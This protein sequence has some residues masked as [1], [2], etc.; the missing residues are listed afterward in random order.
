MALRHG[1]PLALAMFAVD[2]PPRS[3]NPA[4]APSASRS[5]ASSPARSPRS[6]A[7]TTSSPAS[8][9]RPSFIC[10]ATSTRCGPRAP[11]SGSA[12][13]RRAHVPH[14]R[15][16]A[17]N[18]RVPRRRR[19]RPP[20]RAHRPG[21]D[22]RPQNRRSWWRVG[23]GATMSRSTTPRTNRPAWFE[24]IWRRRAH[25]DPLP[26]RAEPRDRLSRRRD[27]AAVHRGERGADVADPPA[28]PPIPEPHRSLWFTDGL[29]R[30]AI[31]ARERQDFATAAALLDQLLASADLSPDDRAAAQWLRGLEDLRQQKFA[32]EPPAAS[33]RPAPRPCSPRSPTACACSR[34]RPGSTAASPARRSR[35]SATW[36]MGQT[37]A[38]V[39]AAIIVTADA[40]ARTD[41]KA[42]AGALYDRYLQRFAEGPRRH[43]VRAKWA[44]LLVEGDDPEQLQ[45]GPRAV[46]AARA[47]RAAQRLRRGG[48]ARIPALEQRLGVRKSLVEA[49]D[50][51]RKRTLARLRDA[52]ARSRYATVIHDADEFL[53]LSSL[54]DGDRCEAL[55]LKGSAIFKQRKR[56]KSRPVFDLA[57]TSLPARRQGQPGHA[58]Q[59]ALPGR[60]RPLRRGRLRARRQALR[61]DRQRVPGP[62]LRRRRADPRRRVVGRGDDH[63][64]ERLA[65]ERVIKDI[66]AGDQAGEARRRLFLL[67]F[68]QDR[69]PDAFALADVRPRPAEARPA[70]ARQAALLPRPRPPAPGPERRRRGRVAR[71][72]GRRP[73]Q[74]RRPADAVPP[75][76]RRRRRF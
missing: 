61:G 44:R 53:R 33:P 10:A 32:R 18:F 28:P 26:R 4:A 30:D 3:V 29:G 19:P 60:P 48:A 35:R 70:R 58:G 8:A 51:D 25:V 37:G 76:R 43:E 57:A 31:L 2:D 75:A 69:V 17:A 1:K 20:P 40:R 11:P 67:A 54:A 24:L 73:A 49:R 7:A 9:T 21:V 55:F 36:P 52:L 56:A 63:P 41:D 46:R 22:Q 59:G 68:T 6:P 14:L 13:A 74:L 12:T 42:G 62:Q 64:R 39:G 66:P 38:L 5:T 15:R 47:R 72:A 16:P 50:V 71:R 34:P 23:Q 45:E 27:A 65:Y